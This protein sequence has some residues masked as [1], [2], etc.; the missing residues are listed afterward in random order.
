MKHIKSII[1]TLLTTF[2]ALPAFAQDFEYEGIWY[3]VLSDNNTCKTRDEGNVYS[4]NL[5]I[6]D[7][8]YDG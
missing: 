1:L 4:G 8:V 5:V 6:P 3:T 7:A 2:L